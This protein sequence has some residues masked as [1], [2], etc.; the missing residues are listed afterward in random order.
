MNKIKQLTTIL[1]AL[2]LTISISGCNNQNSGDA[3][4]TQT[5]F[6]Q[7]IEQEFIDTM[8][9]DYTSLHSFIENPENFGIDLN[10]VE[11]GFGSG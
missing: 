9:S 5:E 10:N 1:L 2:I 11:I 3:D 4:K 7:F 8:E 6:D